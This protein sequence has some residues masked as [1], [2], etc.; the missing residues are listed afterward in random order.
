MGLFIDPLTIMLFSLGI[1]ALMLAIYAYRIS[2]GK[3][4]ASALAIPIMGFGFF[5]AAS[6][7]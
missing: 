6:S 2:A 5:N 3:K 7:F 1:S 4:N